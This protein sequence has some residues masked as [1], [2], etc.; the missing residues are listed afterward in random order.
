MVKKD[1]VDDIQITSVAKETTA[2]EEEKDL[3]QLS[4]EKLLEMRKIKP[5]ATK[6]SKLTTKNMYHES[7]FFKILGLMDFYSSLALVSPAA[8]ALVHQFAD[9]RKLNILV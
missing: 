1:D 3:E 8:L 9:P 2:K 7:F 5:V 6:K 4:L